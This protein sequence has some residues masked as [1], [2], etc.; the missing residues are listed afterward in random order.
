M[1]SARLAVMVMVRVQE[2]EAVQG[3]VADLHARGQ[4]DQARALEKVLELAVSVLADR[5]IPPRRRE[6]LTTSQAAAALGVSRQ[7]LKDWVQAARLRSLVLGGR[8][9]I[10]RDD[11]QEQLDRL[12]DERPTP[13]AGVDALAATQVWHEAALE[14]VP[15][16]LAVRLEALHARM[17]AGEVLSRQ[18]RAEM[19]ALE[20]EVTRVATDALKQ[21]TRA[22]RSP[23]A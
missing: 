18:E 8:T 11:V 14:A 16:D 15:A 5:P 23:S 1:V 7:T 20:R 10:H 17:E 19:A 2:L 4:D 3:L 13:P 21:R 9:L 6:Y 12:L 22:L